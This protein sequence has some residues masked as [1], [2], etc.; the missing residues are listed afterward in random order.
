MPYKPRT[1]DRVFL[2]AREQPPAAAM[3]DHELVGAL[4]DE[5]AGERLALLSEKIFTAFSGRAL[6]ALSP[7]ELHR[8][9]HEEFHDSCGLS[10][11]EAARLAAAIELAKR[12]L[13]PDDGR[14]PI[15]SPQDAC[16]VANGIKSESKEHFLTL[17]LDA[18]NVLIHEE[19]ISIGS[20]NANIVHPRE[21]FKPAISNGAASIILVHNHPSGDVSPSQDD[22]NL[23]S[24]LAEAGH[25]LGIEVLDHVIISDSRF[26]SFRSESYI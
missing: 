10:R 13:W 5:P 21:V 23:T 22:L 8:E 16:R 7:E 3:F 25:L 11:Q 19:V 1:S 20:L 4:L 2:D 17:Y 26:L 12:L 18:R 15:R 6:S 24:R 9:F 14:R